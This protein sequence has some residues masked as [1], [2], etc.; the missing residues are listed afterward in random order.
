MPGE[1]VP[2]DAEI[3]D[4]E[5]VDGGRHLP[6]R[7]WQT[8]AERD[9]TLE[10]VEEVLQRLDR[11]SPNTKKAY[12]AAWN[13]YVRW[14]QE[15]SRTPYPM[16]SAT[17]MSYLGALAKANASASAI[18]IFMATAKRVCL[19]YAEPGD[20]HGWIGAH[21]DVID[22]MTTYRRERNRNPKTRPK[23][24]D[25]ARKAIMRALLDALPDTPAGARDRALMLLGYYM[26]ARRS[27]LVNL[28]HDDIRLTVD[29]L[30][31]Y[32]AWSKTDQAADGKWVAIPSNAEHSAYDPFTALQ[33]WM[34]ACREQGI[35]SG[36][37]FRAVNRYGTIRASGGM[38]GQAVEVLIGRAR[39][40]AYAA[41]KAAWDARHDKAAG[42]IMALIDPDKVKLT[43]HS[44]RRGWATD[45][46][47]A[48]WDLLEIARGGR[49]SPESRVLHIYVEEV[50][51]WLRHQ[52][53]PMPL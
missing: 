43:P 20:I 13:R 48:G 44:L 42:V 53:N 49:W 21:Q 25:G 37:L 8:Q 2:R 30:E 15:R 27:E 18:E 16:T 52:H 39:D 35:T 33:G 41:A 38:D 19:S 32:I 40:R 7:T 6:A 45:A 31:V 4:G 51:K 29:G 28:T 50:E 26:A 10:N 22:W 34:A 24:S 47:L 11:L 14:C 23:R 12:R 3:V 5:L 36:P 46:R 1:L 9:H 17:L